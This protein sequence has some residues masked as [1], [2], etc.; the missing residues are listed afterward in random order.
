[1]SCSLIAPQPGDDPQALLFDDLPAD[2][3]AAV[4]FREEK[5]EY[6]AERL[7]SQ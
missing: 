5:G 6:T 3:R 4:L 7:F 1:M 2:V